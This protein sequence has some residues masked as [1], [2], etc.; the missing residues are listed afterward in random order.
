MLDTVYQTEV[1]VPLYEAAMRW[2]VHHSQLRD[3][4]AVILGVS[5]N[6]H[7]EANLAAVNCGDPL[8]E[9]VVKAFEDAWDLIKSDCPK[10][11]R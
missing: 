1:K 11:Y 8:H 3:D 4:D 2:L 10:Y 9:D 6:E 7:L 5:K